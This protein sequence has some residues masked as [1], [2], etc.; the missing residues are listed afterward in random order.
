MRPPLHPPPP[1]PP[2]L[3]PLHQTLTLCMSL[4]FFYLSLPSLPVSV[5]VSRSIH[6]RLMWRSG[7]IPAP[8]QWNSWFQLGPLLG[9]H[10]HVHTYTL[11]HTKKRKKR[12][13]ESG[14]A[15]FLWLTAL[16]KEQLNHLT[17]ILVVQ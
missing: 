4:T 17:K 10:V 3:P 9:P 1:P 6:V 2:S 12:K 16:L 13:R 14:A 15:C 7:L 11:K 8:S 5:H